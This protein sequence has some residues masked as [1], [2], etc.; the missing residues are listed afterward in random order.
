MIPVDLEP[1][2]DPAA[3][4]EDRLFIHLKLEGDD[5]RELETR[6]TALEAAGQPVVRIALAEPALIGQ[7]FF[8][9]EIATAVAGA[10][11]GI[12]PFDQPDVEAAKVKTRDLVEAYER[13][14]RLDRREP[15]LRDG[16]LS[17]F[18]A[19][20][21]RGRDCAAEGAVRPAEARRLS[22][23]PRLY[24]AQRST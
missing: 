22:G 11:I 9:W 13:T 1:L 3:Y 5:D 2:G 8:R 21:S 16:R 14:G 19:R 6:I 7:E 10:I 20:G 23:L 15:V 24:R 18:A 12:D 17:F 4:G